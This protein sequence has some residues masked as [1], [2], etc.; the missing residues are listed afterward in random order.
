MEKYGVVNGEENEPETLVTVTGPVSL[1]VL[2]QLDAQ[3]AKRRLLKQQRGIAVGPS[4][5]PSGK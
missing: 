1:A 2:A 3:L 5:G 4:I